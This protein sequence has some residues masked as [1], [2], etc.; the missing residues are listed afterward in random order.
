MVTRQQ[1]CSHGSVRTS[2]SLTVTAATI[3]YLTSTITIFTCRKLIDGYHV[4]MLDNFFT[5]K[6]QSISWFHCFVAYTV[7]NVYN[8]TISHITH[9]TIFI[10]VQKVS[11][12]SQKHLDSRKGILHLT[13]WYAFVTTTRLLVIPHYSVLNQILSYCLQNDLQA[14]WSVGCC[15]PNSHRCG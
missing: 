3:L 12:V 13:L 4:Y 7:N 10:A 14:N 6:Q 11:H 5:V 1:Y 15:E 9:I 2:R 8:L